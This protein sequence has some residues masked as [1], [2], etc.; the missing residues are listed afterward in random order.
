MLGVKP[1]LAALLGDLALSRLRSKLIPT[2]TTACRGTPEQAFSGSTR[3]ATSPAGADQDLPWGL[4]I[5]QRT[6][7]RA[8]EVFRRV[9][10]GVR[11]GVDLDTM[12]A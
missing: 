4:I 8:C 2:A 9:R 7:L 6:G 11:N 5:D 3:R 10:A 12:V 1:V